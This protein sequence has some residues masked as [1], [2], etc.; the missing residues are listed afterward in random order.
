MQKVHLAPLWSFIGG[1]IGLIIVS[2]MDALSTAGWI[3]G[4][5]YLGVSNAL[6]TRGL[7]R[8]GAARFGPANTATLVRSTLVG[9]I[10][11]LV[12]SSLTESVSVPLLIGLIFPA[13]AL[14]AVDGWLARRTGTVSALGARFDMEVDAFLILVLS[15]YVSQLLGWWVLALGL[16]RYVY[17][18]AGWALPWLR[19]TVPPRYWRKVV[20]A[21]AGIALAAAASGLFPTWVGVAVT[22]I[23]LG[24]LVESFG[25]DV[26]WQFA[27]R[28]T[29]RSATVQRE[30][31]QQRLPF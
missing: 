2:M 10:T 17:V 11:A 12:A 19:T 25:R 21:F 3:A 1:T 6:L 16:M 13:L 4:L 26:V 5:L 20:A 18:V 24:L 28:S 29:A 14:D 22:L 31:G 7:R 9:L 8:S 27:G 30:A 15:A 23:A